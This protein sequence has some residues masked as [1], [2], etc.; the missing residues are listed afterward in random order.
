MKQFG[1]CLNDKS[2]CTD[3]EMKNLSLAL[4][5]TLEESMLETWNNPENFAVGQFRYGK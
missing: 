1:E 2:K 5:S 4:A 3:A